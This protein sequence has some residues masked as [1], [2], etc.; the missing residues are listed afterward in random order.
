M[1]KFTILLISILGFFSTDLFAQKEQ[2]LIAEAEIALYNENFQTAYN[3]FEYIHQA[4]PTQRSIEYHRLITYHMTNGR[5]KD[6][7]SLVNFRDEK[8]KTDRFYHYWMGRI[9]F[10]RYE[11]ATAKKHFNEFLNTKAYKSSLIINETEHYLREIDL[12]K[13]FYEDPDYYEIEPIPGINSSYAELSASFFGDNSELV[14]TSSRPLNGADKDQFHIYHSSKSDQWSEP[15]PLLQLG[16]FDK[17]NAKV[18]IVNDDGKLFF[19]NDKKADLFFTHFDGYGWT[20]PEEFDQKLKSSLIESHF[21]IADLEDHV[22]FAS[23]KGGGGLDLFESY[24][25]EFGN[26]SVPQPLKGEINSPY[27]EDSPFLSHDGQKLYFSSNRP[28][29]VGGYDVFVAELNPTTLEWNAPVNLGFPINT[30][31]DEINFQ[32]NPDDKTGYLSS[33]R[34]HSQGD[35]DIY[36]FHEIKKMITQGKITNI[37]DGLPLVNAVIKFHPKTYEDEAFVANIDQDGYYMVNLPVK[38]AF[39]VEIL[40]D[41]T[42]IYNIDFESKTSDITKPITK[43]YEIRI[44]YDFGTENEL[45]HFAGNNTNENVGLD[46][47]GTK[48]REGKKAIISNIYFKN[49]SADLKSRA[50]DVIQQL[51][52]MLEQHPELKVEIAGHT[53]GLEALSRE[54]ELSLERANV[55]VN[56]LISWGIKKNQLVAR[57]YGSSHP[58]ASNDDELEGRELNRRIEVKVIE[59]PITASSNHSMNSSSTSSGS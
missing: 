19:Y 17:E 3:L 37:K 21:F 22:I 18:E 16:T 30:T 52:I 44:P 58:L 59:V 41:E 55:I 38:E 39:H 33:N 49:E 13:A 23:N 5:G 50:D 26:W 28:E 1:R 10:A 25:D 6:L 42:V 54:E 15:S 34:L 45:V 11:F 12:A 7:T 51:F 27:A 24:K 53:D 2:K 36:Y 47:L 56:T 57:G 32:L 35:F 43:N 8:A 40:V 20:Q 14:F 48:F 29:S 31:D 46:M 9:Y 4:Y